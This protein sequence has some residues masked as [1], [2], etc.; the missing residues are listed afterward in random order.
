VD[1]PGRPPPHARPLRFGADF[2]A[3][4]ARRSRRTSCRGLAAG[5]GRRRDRPG[6][7]HLLHAGLDRS[8]AADRRGRTP[9]AGL[10]GQR[11]TA[12]RGEPRRPSTRRSAVRIGPSAS[13]RR[14]RRLVRDL[15]LHQ[16]AARRRLRTGER[17]DAAARPL[18]GGVRRPEAPLARFASARG[19]DPGAADQ[20]RL[21]RRDLHRH[22]RP[23]PQRLVGSRDRRRGGRDHARRD[24]WRR[25]RS[26][27]PQHGSAA[28]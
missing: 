16:P 7:R 21:H 13:V 6:R 5:H 26:M 11:G 3:R 17:G 25:R 10:G 15:G 27:D 4:I 28:A 23:T 20:L 22:P 24:L 12:V 1:G 9:R 14:R 18:G 19:P 2:H 8:L